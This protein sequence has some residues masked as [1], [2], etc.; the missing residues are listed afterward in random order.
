MYRWLALASR[1]DVNPKNPHFVLRP[2]EIQPLSVTR[3]FSYHF[4]C[5]GPDL[6]TTSEEILQPGH[7]AMFAKSIELN[8][9]I[10]I[11]TTRMPTFKDD[12]FSELPIFANAVL[13]SSIHLG[14][15]NQSFCSANTRNGSIRQVRKRDGRCIITGTTA[16]TLKTTWIVVPTFGGIVNQHY[17]AFSDKNDDSEWYNVKNGVTM[18]QELADLFLNNDIAIDV[19]DP[20]KLCSEKLLATIPTYISLP[21]NVPKELGPDLQ[22]FRYHLKWSITVNG[23]AGDVMDYYDR[24][25]LSSAIDELLG[26]EEDEMAG[27]EDPMWQTEI[28]QIIMAWLIHTKRTTL[29]GDE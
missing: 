15:F 20:R 14:S 28:G 22:M 27:P 9:D 26:E 5:I 12:C 13:L 24:R 25:E 29:I 23:N 19:D 4:E 3:Y 7:Y 17:P 16:E 1:L 8:C 11:F 6:L 2:V 10:S 21:R 18:R